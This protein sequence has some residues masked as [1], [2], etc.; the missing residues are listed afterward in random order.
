MARI[1][2][3]GRKAEEKILKGIEQYRKQKGRVPIAKALPY[4]EAIVEALKALKSVRKIVI[5][6]SLR[7]WKD[8]I[9]DIDI[10]VVSGN[11]S[12]VM[13][14]FTRLDGVEEVLA[15]GETK[16]S[17]IFRGINAD[18]RVVPPES[19]GAAT[20]YLSLIHI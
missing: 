10:L 11:P 7:R 4:A 15:K 17:V 12:E 6:G 14:A 3:L 13:D 9:G 2:G 8:T 5:A 18:L 16:S 1:A 19:F 20:H